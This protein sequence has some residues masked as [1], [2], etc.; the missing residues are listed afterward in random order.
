MIAYDADTV[1]LVVYSSLKADAGGATGVCKSWCS[2]Q[3]SGASLPRS[4]HPC[5]CPEACW[6]LQG[7]PEGTACKQTCR[8]HPRIAMAET[9]GYVVAVCTPYCMTALRFFKNLMFVGLMSKNEI[10][11]VFFSAGWAVEYPSVLATQVSTIS[12]VPASLP[13]ALWLCWKGILVKGLLLLLLIPSMPQVLGSSSSWLF[14]FQNEWQK[15]QVGRNTYLPFYNPVNRSL[16][17]ELIYTD[18]N[19]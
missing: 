4:C 6:C 14:F 10:Q 15:G 5:P 11:D 12:G 8:K 19:L 3:D 2:L 16:G 9:H 18:L 13:A 1:L 7:S 17:A